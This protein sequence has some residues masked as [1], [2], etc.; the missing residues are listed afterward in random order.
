M[1][2]RYL[3]GDTA[4]PAGVSVVPENLKK[5]IA[6]NGALLKAKTAALKETA[7][8]NK[9]A[10]TEMKKRSQAYAKEYAKAEKQLVSL[11][12]QAKQAGNFFREPEAKLLFVVRITGAFK[13]F[14]CL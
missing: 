4:A 7:A 2:S 11:R 12:R 13:L 5:K 14:F 8:K 3:I 10:R 6:R 9:V 1:A